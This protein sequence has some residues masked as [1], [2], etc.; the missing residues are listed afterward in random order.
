MAEGPWPGLR[1]AGDITH[2]EWATA[3]MR[4]RADVGLVVPAA[5]DAHIRLL[6]RRADGHRWADVDP[7]ALIDGIQAARRW[8]SVTVSSTDP[9]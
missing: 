2:V 8:E 6:H 3:Q 9:W 4:G 1:P 5:F 7:R